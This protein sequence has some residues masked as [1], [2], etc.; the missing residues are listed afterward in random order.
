MVCNIYILEQVAVCHIFD[1][2]RN[3]TVRR[4]QA[5]YSSDLSLQ[6]C[7]EDKEKEKKK[8]T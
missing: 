2:Y 5:E 6:N 8:N 1:T 4:S 7:K 3:F